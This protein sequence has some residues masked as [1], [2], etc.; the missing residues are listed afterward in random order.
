[1]RDPTLRKE[2]TPMM[3]RELPKEPPVI[4]DKKRGKQIQ[5]GCICRVLLQSEEEGKTLW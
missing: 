4:I 5:N 3:V 2:R 1:V